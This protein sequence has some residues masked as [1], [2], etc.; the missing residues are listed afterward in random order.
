[1]C[2]FPVTFVV[3][4]SHMS[5]CS[6]R[7]LALSRVWYPSQVCAFHLA[8]VAYRMCGPC[9]VWP[10]ACVAS[11]MCGLCVAY[12]SNLACVAYPSV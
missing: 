7:V 4:L 12:A 10:I 2:C 1:M 5:T 3:A 8:C 11:V 9:D 6:I